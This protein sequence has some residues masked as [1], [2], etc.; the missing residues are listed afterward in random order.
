MKGILG[1]KAGMTEVSTKDGKLIPVTVVEVPSNVVMQ[2][3]TV[4][5]DGY[6][7]IKLGVFE[8]KESKANRS[9]IGQAKKQIL[10]LS[11]T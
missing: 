1:R 4:E 5:K 3:K 10:L 9:E 2:V 7:A 11:A 8:K 6:N